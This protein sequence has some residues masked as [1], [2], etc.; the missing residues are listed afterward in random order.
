MDTTELSRRV[1]AAYA[2]RALLSQPLYRQAVAEVL[3]LLDR[4]VLRTAEPKDGKWVTYPW[5][6]RAILLYFG[7][8]KMEVQEVGPFEYHDK[9]PL[10]RNLA[11]AKV[12]VVPP[13]TVRY[14]AHLEAGVV[15]M[16]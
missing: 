15:L 1:E 8:R 2:E 7:M 4:G 13:G 11:A 6:G 3:D 12:R 14:G 5:I 9:I 16:P 10:K